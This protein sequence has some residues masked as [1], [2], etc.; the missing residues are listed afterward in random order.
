MIIPVQ[1]FFDF[2]IV[3]IQNMVPEGKFDKCKNF[4]FPLVLIV[5]KAVGIKISA[6][7]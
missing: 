3:V 2:V 7:N 1:V 4:P 5:Q 6:I